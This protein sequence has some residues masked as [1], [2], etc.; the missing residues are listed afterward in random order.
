MARTTKNPNLREAERRAARRR[1][2][3]IAAAREYAAAY[4]QKL[5]TRTP[6]ADL[7]DAVRDLGEAES[8]LIDQRDRARPATDEA[9]Q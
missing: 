7:R 3:V 4:S 9:A 6:L 2:D 8:E 1:D 5:D